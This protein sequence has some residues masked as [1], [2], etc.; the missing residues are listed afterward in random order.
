MDHRLVTEPRYNGTDKPYS[1]VC[2]WR[3]KTLPAVRVHATRENRAARRLREVLEQAVEAAKKRSGGDPNKKA[4]DEAP[5]TQ[6][7][8]ADRNAAEKKAK[9]EAAKRDGD[10]A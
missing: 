3:G 4:K 9:P 7:D 2:G 6:A 8:K 10:D 1:C 5:E